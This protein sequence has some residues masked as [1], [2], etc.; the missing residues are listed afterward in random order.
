[1]EN[2]ISIWDEEFDDFP[3]RCCLCDEQIEIKE[4][5]WKYGHNPQPL[6]KSNQDRCCDEC[7]EELVMNVRLQLILNGVN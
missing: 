2:N 1:M 3:L 4:N 7:N 5:E 6:S